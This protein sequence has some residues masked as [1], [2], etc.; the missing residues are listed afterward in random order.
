MSTKEEREVL[1][2]KA[3]FVIAKAAKDNKDAELY[4]LMISRVLRV[5]DDIYDDD[6]EVTRERLMETF[7][8]LFVKIPTNQ[9]YLTYQDVLL[10][11]HLSMWNAW[12]A[13]NYYSEGDA[14]DKIYCHVWR[15]TCNEL[16][17]IV[18]LLTGGYEHMN[19]TSIKMRTLFKKELGE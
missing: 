7:E 2:E 19:E 8:C 3:D 14:T 16:V 11:Q 17:P 18:A 12:I 13:S 6:Y 15:D 10:S 1:G 5:I 4:L 9:F